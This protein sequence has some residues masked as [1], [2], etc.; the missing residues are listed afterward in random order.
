MFSARRANPQPSAEELIDRG[1]L[2]DALAL[3]GARKSLPPDVLREVE[4]RIAQGNKITAKMDDYN[5]GKAKGREGAM[6]IW[7]YAE[8]KVHV[9]KAHAA[10]DAPPAQLLAVLREWDLIPRWNPYV[11]QAVITAEPS[12]MSLTGGLEMYLPAPFSN[13]AGMFHAEGMDLLDTHGYFL[14]TFQSSEE[15][16]RQLPDSLRKFDLLYFGE[17]GFRIT[18]LTSGAAAGAFAEGAEILVSDRCDCV[19]VVSLDPGSLWVPDWLVNLILGVIAPFIYKEVV[20]ILARISDEYKARMEYR[21]EL[22][23]LLE[24]RSNAHVE[25]AGSAALA[26]NRTPDGGAD[27]SINSGGSAQPVSKSKKG[28][29]FRLFRR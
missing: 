11:P 10:F 6:Q 28:G 29:L 5:W 21:A 20:A 16:M 18:P 14:G 17:S 13:R 9:F 3:P 23:P 1:R 24:K 4:A 27:A 2:V 15:A 12:L 7:H 19:F 25:K 8:G 26:A 22:Y